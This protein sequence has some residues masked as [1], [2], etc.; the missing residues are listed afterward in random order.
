MSDKPAYRVPTMAEVRALDAT[1]GLTCV[2]TFSGCGG[3]S[4]GY[5]MA[6]FDVRGAAEFVPLAADVYELNSDAPV[7]R[8]DV[9]DVNGAEWINSLGI[10]VGDLDVLDGSPP[11]AAFSLA[12]KRSESWG[13][14]KSYSDTQQR[15]DDLFY[16]YARLLREIKPRAF[17]AENVPGLTTGVAKGYFQRIMRDLTDSGYKVRAA[18]LA[19]HWL[20]VPQARNRVIIVGFRNDLDVDFEYPAPLPYFYSMRDAL[21]YLDGQVTPA[22]GETGDGSW[23]AK[24]GWTD[25][26]SPS[27]TIGAG[28]NTG[29]GRFPPMV[30]ELATASNYHGVEQFS[31]DGPVP[32]LTSC[33]IAASAHARVAIVSDQVPRPFMLD[34]KII[35]PETGYNIGNVSKVLRLYYPGR[36]LRRFT[37]GELRRICGFPDDFALKGSYPQRW[38][39]LGRA[40][41]PV[42]MSH[43]ARQVAEALND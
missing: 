32:T 43:V 14:V 42:M 29:N 37:V 6:G 30:T 34:G 3:S 4:L 38:E 41:P 25:G 22:A 7:N 12:G 40:V 11:C 16:E 18:K 20:G 15:S 36:K 26:G 8:S 21:P 31:L 13:V 2:S 23:S 27:R 28:E 39:R 5:R 24:P 33:G 17:V 19:G 9:R 35:D 10:D 1:N